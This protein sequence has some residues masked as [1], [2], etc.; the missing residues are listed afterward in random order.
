MRID[1]PVLDLQDRDREREREDRDGYRYTGCNCR[2]SMCL[3]MYCVCFAGGRMCD[4]VL[5]GICRLA[6]ANRV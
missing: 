6:Y 3:K 2:K 4:R 5:M 1:V